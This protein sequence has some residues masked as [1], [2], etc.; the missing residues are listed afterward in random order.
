MRDPDGLTQL[1]P[2]QVLRTLYQPLQEAD[3]LASPLARQWVESGRLTPFS[4]ESSTRVVSPRLPFVSFPS[5]WCAAQLFAAAE[6]T[7]Q[8]ETE[9]VEAGFELKD[10]SAWNVIF[11]GTLPRF[12]DLLSVQPLNQRLWWAG[13]QFGRH[14]LLPLLMARHGG[15]TAHECFRIWRDGVPPAAAR[16]AIGARRW[17]TRYWPLM[18]EAGGAQ[19]APSDVA[20]ADTKPVVAYRRNLHRGLDWMLAGLKPSAQPA[21]G[22]A[23]VWGDYVNQ[24]DHYAAGAVQSKRQTVAGWLDTVRPSWVV[25]LGCNSGEFSGLAANAG[26]RV[27]AIDQDHDAIQQLFLQ[28][29]GDDRIFPLL[30]QL[31]DLPTGRGWAGDEFPGLQTR[32]HQSCDLLMMLALIHHLAIAAAVPLERIATF[33]AAVSRRWLIVEWIADDDSQLQLLCAQRRRRPVDFSIS[34]QRAAFEQ[35]GWKV[36]AEAPLPSSTRLLAL[37]EQAR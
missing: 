15:L 25:D 4:V 8:L 20:P 34:R 24:R 30:A 12:C 2:N 33:A 7:L 36:A 17:L 29:G 31:D 23:T 28:R 11:D 1:A 6:L 9:A 19:P 18:A 14:F 13:G 26:A 3:F 21:A 37:L 16:Q 22:R 5:E 10:A 27:I 32:L 35:A